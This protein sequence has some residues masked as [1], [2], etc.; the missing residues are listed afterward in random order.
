MET[1]LLLAYMILGYWAA[2]QTV[3]AGKIR[4]GTAYNLFLTRFIVGFVLGWILIPV[5]II[6]NSSAS[7]SYHTFERGKLI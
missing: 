6:K 1:I 7:N 5:S 2:G 3:Y 4:I